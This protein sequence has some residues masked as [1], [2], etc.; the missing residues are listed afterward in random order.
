MSANEPPLS[1]AANNIVLNY[2]LRHVE[3]EGAAAKILSILAS[4]KEGEFLRTLS[5]RGLMISGL[6]NQFKNKEKFK[7]CTDMHSD[8]SEDLP[9][10][11]IAVTN[12]SIMVYEVLC[13]VLHERKVILE[14]IGG[15]LSADG[16]RRIW[17]SR[18]LN[19]CLLASLF[20]QVPGQEKI[21]AKG[22]QTLFET[23]VIES[24]KVIELDKQ[25]VSVLKTTFPD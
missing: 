23:E 14:L 7:Q 5:T 17:R 4:M 6:C 8:L 19:Q 24:E 1:P 11:L 12:S 18:I 15:N 10:C 16:D 9:S 21:V 2:H 3:A 13:L 22:I 25:F 20:E